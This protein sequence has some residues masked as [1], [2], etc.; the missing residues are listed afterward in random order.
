MGRS[1]DLTIDKKASIVTLYK[2]GIAQIEIAR[3]IP[4]SKA[5]VSKTIK[6]FKEE[7][8][9]IFNKRIYKKR[10]NKTTKLTEYT[11]KK[12]VNK[13]RQ[14]TLS[15]ITNEWNKVSRVGV[16]RMTTLRRLNDLG[17]KS[18]M[19]IKKPLLNNKQRAKRLAWAKLHQHWTVDQWRTVIWSDESRFCVFK[20]DG[21]QRVW[22]QKGEILSPKCTIPTVKFP[23]SCMMW[24]SMSANGVGTLINV[25][26]SINSWKYQ[27][28]LGEGLLPLLEPDQLY[29]GHLFQQDL[30]PAHSSKSTAEW[31]EEYC[32]EVLG[33]PGNSPD[34]NPIENLWGIL[35]RR[36]RKHIPT[37]KPSLLQILDDE[38]K[39]I[40]PQDCKNLIDSMPRR[41]RAVIN[42]KGGPT[43][44]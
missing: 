29:H 38:W 4:C 32:I 42:A 22:R 34:L 17:F 37:S 19:A 25:L 30:A 35:K 21:P 36:V 43:N 16:S 10:E 13:G 7:G 18:K 33:W 26:G 40:T 12:I 3:K 44:Y 5:T 27:D 24:G 8:A 41:I 23:A 14:K 6:I 1:V 15:E 28:I 9:A 39:K 11:L 2:E 20:N 31:F